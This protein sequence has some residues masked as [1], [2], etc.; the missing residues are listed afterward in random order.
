M[1]TFILRMKQMLHSAGDDFFARLAAAQPS[2]SPKMARLAAF[3]S[4]NYVQVAFMSTREL[5][6]A[7]DVSHATVVRFPAVLGYAD[8]DALRA[9]I[10]DRVNFDLTGVERLQTLPS[11]NRSPSALLRRIIDADFESLHALAQTFSEAQLDRFVDMILA[12]N[13]VTIFGFR[14]VSPL[15]MYFGY[16]LS[17]IKPNVQAYTHAD[18]SLYDRVRLMNA[19]DVLI[20]I[21]FA[22][23]PTDLVALTRYAHG[24]GVRILAIT[25]SPLSPVLPLA[26]VALFAKASMLDFVGSLAAPAALIN[27]VVSEAGVRLGEKALERLQA[28]EDAASTAGIYVRAGSRSTPF[29]G[30]LLAWEDKRSDGQQGNDG[31]SDDYA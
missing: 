14:Y 3:V 9:S 20:V 12:A 8:F 4:E 19:D 1:I 15:T 31:Q 22:R 21:T 2:L 28:L 27:C 17:K 29:E 24:L 10:Q 23:Y 7:A 16:S 18:S 26:E 25:D 30:R 13:R 11:T 5:A 6:N